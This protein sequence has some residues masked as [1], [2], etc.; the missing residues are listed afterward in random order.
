MDL[1]CV[2]RQVTESER[3]DLANSSIEEEAAIAAI[4]SQVPRCN[5]ASSSVDRN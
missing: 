2:V 4:E 5:S 3:V 1:L